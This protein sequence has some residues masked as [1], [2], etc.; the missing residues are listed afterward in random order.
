MYR[1]SWYNAS[2]NKVLGSIDMLLISDTNVVSNKKNLGK[3]LLILQV[4]VVFLPRDQSYD[5]MYNYEYILV[6]LNIFTV[7]P[8]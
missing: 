7:L 2:T 4:S 8:F 6:A 1:N 5:F 3:L